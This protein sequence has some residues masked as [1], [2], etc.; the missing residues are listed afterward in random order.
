M[1]AHDALKTT[2]GIGQFVSMAYL[3]DLTDADLMRRAAPGAN[4]INWQLGHLILDDHNH[5]TAILPG[6]MPPLPKDFERIYSK[7]S[8]SS[9]DTKA[10]LDKATLLKAF[11]EQRAA[12]LK[13]LD[14]VSAEDLDRPAPEKYLQYAKNWGAIFEL[15]GSHW[16]M[17]CGQW[18]IVRRQMGKPALF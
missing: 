18:A 4:H 6:A 15:A 11:E 10:F 12:L 7:D 9:D 17:H 5:I 14:S 13:A 2:I 16:L 3:A 1:N 8:A